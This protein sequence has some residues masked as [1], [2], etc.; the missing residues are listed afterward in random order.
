VERPG[1]FTA[2]YRPGPD[3]QLR[4]YLLLTLIGLKQEIMISGLVDTGAD[5]SVL[6]IDYAE[7]LGYTVDDLA[8]VEVGQVE[9]SASAWLAQ[10]PCGAI[11]D[12]IPEHEF[13]IAPLFVASLNALWGRADLMMAFTVSVSE[14]DRELTL[15]PS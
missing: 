3:G 13:E 8:P 4:P 10:K 6:P 5:R 1:S 12:G 14:K 9:G 15:Q 11:V 7:E 2:P